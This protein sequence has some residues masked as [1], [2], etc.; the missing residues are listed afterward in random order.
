MGDNI[1]LADR[2]GVRTP[3]QWGPGSTGDFSEAPIGSLYAPVIND[4]VYGPTRVNA[5]AQNANPNS[6]LNV[7]RTMIA[8]RKQHQIFGRG[9]FEWLTLEK[10]NIAA[11]QRTYLDETLLA[12]HNLSDTKQE[13]SFRTKKPVKSMT[14]LLAQQEYFLV[15][16]KFEIE[17]MPYQYLWLK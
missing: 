12:I 14:D 6:L 8:T 7:I 4:A 5:K 17:L 3:M 2:N 16:D 10:E 15:K 1:W 11:F 9:T 13:I